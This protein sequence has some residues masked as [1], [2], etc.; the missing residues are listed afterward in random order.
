[1][2]LKTLGA[3]LETVAAKVEHFVVNEIEVVAQIPA[4]RGSIDGAMSMGAGKMAQ[5]IAEEIAK[6]CPLISPLAE[7]IIQ[8]CLAHLEQDVDKW[9]TEHNTGEATP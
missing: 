1:M 9:L 3:K 7:P 6:A 5:M 2:D 4:V 8:A